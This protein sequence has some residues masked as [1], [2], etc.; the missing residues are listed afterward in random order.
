MKKHLQNFYSFLV[1]IVLCNVGMAQSTYRTDIEISEQASVAL[2][3]YQ[4]DLLINTEDLIL[5]GKMNS[6]GSDLRFYSDSCLTTPLEYWIETGI[7]TNSTLVWVL[8]PSIPANTISK[9]YMGYGDPMAT[10]TSNF[11]TTF[12]AA[13]ISGGAPLNLTGTINTDWFQLDAGDILTL[14][15]GAPLS[16]NARKIL[17]HGIVNG[18]GTGYV[19]GIATAG[20]QA[21]SGPGGGTPSNPMNSGCGGGSYAGI[22]GTG[23]YDS[24]DTPGVGGAIYGTDSGTDFDMG[25]GGASSDLNFGGNGGGAFAMNA[26]YIVI[27]GNINMDGGSAQQPGGGRGAGGGS[28]GSV[29][30]N[31]KEL[32]VS[33]SITA[34]GGSGSIGTST[35]NDDGGSGAGGRIKFFYSGTFNN[36]G[37]TSVTGGTVGTYGTAAGPTSGASGVVYQGAILVLDNLVINQNPEIDF[38]FTA[39]ISGNTEA[40][41]GD[42]ITLSA[43]GAYANYTWSTSDLTSSINVISTGIYELIAEAPFGCILDTVSITVTFN[44]L[45]AI[46]LGVDQA[47]CASS[48][49]VLDA[50]TGFDSYIWS[51]GDPTQTTLISNGGSY[52]VTVT[53]VAGCANSDTINITENPLPVLSATST[54]EIAGNDGAID[55]TVIGGTPG[56]TYV[57]DNGAG[58]SEDPTGLSSNDYTV[59]VTDAAG[60]ADTLLVTVGSQVGLDEL[61]ASFKI[62]PNPSNGPFTIQAT[63]DFNEIEGVVYDN[64]GRVIQE[65]KFNG[66]QAIQLDLSN[67]ESGVYSLV[68]KVKNE[69]IYIKLI[70]Q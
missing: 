19:G 61:N 56:Y 22:G 28:G 21:G 65:I 58:T 16:I 2:T 67:N 27:A 68:L 26:E 41:D 11:A 1:I 17:I 55:L 39:S 37:T 12:P 48:S 36:S 9:I 42:T 8:V 44:A 33:G 70:N 31:G 69:T 5:Q 29:I 57:W 34:N 40:C 52:T 64:S 63:Q 4:I 51:N 47:F 3:N 45:P 25:S 35:A 50:G 54:D 59:I 7:N 18:N 38:N 32:I 46:D 13:I 60:C 30:A 15:N 6:D 62:F 66:M 49:I 20:G 14:T 53:N 10:S 24:G 23:G 43:G